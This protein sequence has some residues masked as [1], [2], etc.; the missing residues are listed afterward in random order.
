MNFYQYLHMSSEYKNIDKKTMYTLNAEGGA[1][2]LNAMNLLSN[3]IMP[4][5]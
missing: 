3:K 5:T 4:L 1:A 2:T